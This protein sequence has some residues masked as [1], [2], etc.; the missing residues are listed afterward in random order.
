MSFTAQVDTW[1]SKSKRR[2]DAVFRESVQ[3]L[4]EDAQTPRGHGGRMPVD[5]GFL[6][7]SGQI[8]LSAMP[9]ANAER[10]NGVSYAWSP[11][12]VS[13]RLAGARMGETV[14]FGWTASYAPHVEYGAR[15][16]SPALF[17]RGAAAKWQ[18]IVRGVVAELRARS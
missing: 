9:A 5:T 12:D 8:S 7:A 4:I 3:R 15:G 13:V 18:H 2:M 16:R 11:H 17:M 10:Q 1:V 14:Y 6:R